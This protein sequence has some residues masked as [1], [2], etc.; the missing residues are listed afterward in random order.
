MWRFPRDWRRAH[1]SEG[2]PPDA[3]ALQFP[4]LVSKLQLGNRIAL[5]RTKSRQYAGAPQPS[6]YRL[7]SVYPP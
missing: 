6:K 2:M 3:A 4:A 7:P 5:S 1:A